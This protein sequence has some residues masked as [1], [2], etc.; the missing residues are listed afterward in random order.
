MLQPLL[1]MVNYVQVRNSS[2]FSQLFSH[3]LEK[4]EGMEKVSLQSGTMC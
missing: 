3:L 2:Q 4:I 1:G